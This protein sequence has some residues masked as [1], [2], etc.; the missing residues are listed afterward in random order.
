MRPEPS[1]F[2]VLRF[3]AHR[4]TLGLRP[5]AVG[6]RS[7]LFVAA[8]RPPRG[9]RT[10]GDG[11]SSL[12]PSAGFSSLKGEGFLILEHQR[13]L[14]VA[15]RRRRRGFGALAAPMPQNLFDLVAQLIDA[16]EFRRLA[17]RHQRIEITVVPP[18]LRPASRAE[19]LAA[20]GAKATAPV[21]AEPCADPLHETEEDAGVAEMPSAGPLK[22]R[23]LLVSAEAL[24]R[25]HFEHRPGVWEWGGGFAGEVHFLAWGWRVRR[26]YLP[27]WGGRRVQRAGWGDALLQPP[28]RSFDKLRTD[29]PHKGRVGARKHRHARRSVWLLSK[30]ALLRRSLRDLAG[31]RRQNPAG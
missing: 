21:V 27:R 11:Q 4:G 20:A 8:R 24:M 1:W 2:C 23:P 25:R 3:A 18:V 31:R 15:H 29:P 17:G 19:A 16:F 12:R 7:R 13:H 22:M 14:G 28:P 30:S 26:P 5:T 6:F 9:R 10:P